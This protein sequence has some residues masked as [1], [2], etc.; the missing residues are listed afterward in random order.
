MCPL[1]GGMHG[2]VC[3]C[4]QGVPGWMRSY[5]EGMPGYLCSMQMECLGVNVIVLGKSIDQ[6]KQRFFGL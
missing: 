1:A 4:A 6:E 3:P 5:A 2:K